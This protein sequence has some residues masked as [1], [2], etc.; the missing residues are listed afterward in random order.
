[1]GIANSARRFQRVRMGA[2]VGVLG[3]AAVIGASCTSGTAGDRNDTKLPT[4]TEVAKLLAPPLVPPAIDRNEPALVKVDLE[5]KTVRSQL[6]DGVEYEYWT[7]NGTV[8][9]P[10]IRVRLGDTVELTLKNS[11]QSR[12]AHSID[13]HAVN[14]PGGG[15]A[16][17]TVAP[18][19]SKTFRF[20]PLN[21]GLY[22]YHCA[23][24]PVPHHITQGLYGLILVEPQG[25]LSKVDK[26]F[27]VMEGELYTAGKLGDKGLQ[28]FSLDKLVAEEPEYVVFNGAVGS[29][30]GEK[31]LKANVND[32]VR[33]YF[34]DGGPNLISSFHV[35]GEIFDEVHQEGATEAAHNVQTTLVPAGGATWVD[36]Q[37]DVP[38]TY[39]LVD[40]SLSRLFKGAAGHLVVS[41]PEA[42]YIFQPT[43]TAA[44]H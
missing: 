9:G 21:P 7:F 17:T 5:A 6:A 35:I 16:V 3:L 31:A 4:K 40:H 43:G 30:T 10:M 33:I 23:V 25:G 13:L 38:G 24:P 2:V 42:P 41:G 18:G 26:E 14:G 1:M 39:V 15:A 22:V 32:K 8:P 29:I 20:R 11:D 36:F 19:Q 44:G 28:E 27:Y 12:V 37:V 34:G